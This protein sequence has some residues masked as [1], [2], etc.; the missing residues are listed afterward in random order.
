MSVR[1]EKVGR[2]RNKRD[3]GKETRE[4]KKEKE[5][6]EGMKREREMREGCV[7][8]STRR[9]SG[10]ETIRVRC[11]SLKFHQKNRS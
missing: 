1:Q 7:V 9:D 5:R 10:H 3:G 4:R 6:G 11:T 2:D 8:F